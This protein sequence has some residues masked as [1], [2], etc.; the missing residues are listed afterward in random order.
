MNEIV[1]SMVET[2]MGVHLTDINMR[3]ETISKELSIPSLSGPPRGIK[4]HYL[5]NIR[6]MSNSINILEKQFELTFM[7]SEFKSLVRL[8]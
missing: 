7:K 1:G 5:E 8:E 4:E 2:H 6:V 3:F